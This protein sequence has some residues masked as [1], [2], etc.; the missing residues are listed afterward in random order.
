[1]LWVLRAPPPVPPM[2]AA[3]WSAEA[4]AMKVEVGSS[5][6]RDAEGEEAEAE[7]RGEGMMEVLASSKA[8][9]VIIY[10]R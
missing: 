4:A 1:M 3:V 8:A 10:F 6:G 9:K 7:G 5:A 2:L